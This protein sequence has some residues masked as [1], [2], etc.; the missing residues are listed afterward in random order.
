MPRRTPAASNVTTEPAADV[1]AGSVLI[2]QSGDLTDLVGAE[3]DEGYVARDYRIKVGGVHHEHVGD[4]P[5]GRWIYR[6][7]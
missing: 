2:D 1:A 3:P 4:A 5:D 6:R 7:S